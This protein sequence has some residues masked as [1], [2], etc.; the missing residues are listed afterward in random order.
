MKIDI[1]L[2]RPAESDF[3]RRADEYQV[4]D[5]ASMKAAE[6]ELKRLRRDYRALPKG[7]PRKPTTRKAI[8]QV[9]FA[10]LKLKQTLLAEIVRR[11]PDPDA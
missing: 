5:F 1:Q 6:A 10:I 4:K 7:D 3:D 2:V 8:K 9:E 11:M